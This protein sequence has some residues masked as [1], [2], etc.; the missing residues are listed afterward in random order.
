MKKCL[1]TLLAVLV[2]KTSFASSDEA[3]RAA[4]ELLSMSGIE[5]TFSAQVMV[6][7]EIARNPS[8]EP[9]RGVMEDFFNKYMDYESARPELAALY[10]EAFSEQELKQIVAFYKT[11]AGKKVISIMP[12]LV[13]KVS[14]IG[15][16]RLQAN[17]GE[18][19]AAIQ[20]E[21][22]RMSSD[23]QSTGATPGTTAQ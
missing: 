3:L 16:S 4:E 14:Q 8:L 10:M 15:M 19:K 6:D 9:F 22:A 1:V 17:I 23:S 11:P 12:Q 7:N 13:K 18:L 21:A 20:Q 5:K 2:V